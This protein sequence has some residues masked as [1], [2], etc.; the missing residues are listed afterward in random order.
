M[1]LKILVVFFSLGTIIGYS[2]F[3]HSQTQIQS[4]EPTTEFPVTPSDPTV[5]STSKSGPVNLL[6][7]QISNSRFSSSKSI[8]SLIKW[9]DFS[10]KADT[11]EPVSPEEDSQSAGKDFGRL[12]VRVV[13][14]TKSAP[15]FS[16]SDVEGPPIQD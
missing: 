11:I 5:F 14:S 9:S 2:F 16:P 12:N 3:K 13:P 1:V 8:D 7:S 15:V 6:P 4:A 10:K